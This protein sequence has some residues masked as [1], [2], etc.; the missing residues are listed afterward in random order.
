MKMRYVTRVQTNLKRFEKLISSKTTTRVLD[1][2]YRSIYK[3]RSM[4][5]DELREYVT[6]D[7]IKDVDWKS[8]ARSRK[9][10][11]RQYIAEKKHNI[12]FVLDTNRS[13]LAD[14]QGH[15][16]KRELALMS[17]GSLAYMVNQNGDYIGA[18]FPTEKS[19]NYKP[20]GIG[21]ANI[22]TILSAYDAQTLKDS[23][24]DI[25]KTIDYIV[26]NFRKKMIV[27]IVTDTM[28]IENISE[29]N[30]K[31]LLVANDV[32]VIH[33]SDVDF[34]N[35]GIYDTGNKRYFDPFFAK[36]KKLIE[37]LQS[38]K[39]QHYN[40]A[41]DKL[42]KYGI[43]CSTIDYIDELD[44]EMMDLLNKHKSEVLFYGNNH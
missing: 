9:L 2:S 41:M 31:R 19:V 43:P 29:V 6:G 22:E 20:F 15:E 30:L 24:T 8:S 36:N 10:L 16:D 11:V 33:I 40:A 37:K 3:G 34:E 7:E 38:E 26:R 32:L 17:A 28:G 13:M 44:S 4:N 5:F 14:S 18:I 12:L 23:K 42:K 27:V 21:L 35:A 25:D 1:G 39:E